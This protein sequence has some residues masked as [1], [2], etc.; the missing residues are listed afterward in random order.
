MKTAISIPD[1]T[2]RQVDERAAAL[3]VSR[4]EFFARAVQSYFEVLDAD[5]WL[6]RIN[7]AVDLVGADESTELAVAASRRRLAADEGEW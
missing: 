5:S 3:G 2:F 6:H 1:E 7:A 4:S